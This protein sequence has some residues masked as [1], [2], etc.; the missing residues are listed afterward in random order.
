M[1]KLLLALL[2]SAVL[3][4]CATQAQQKYKQ[5]EMQIGSAFRSMNGCYQHVME[6]PTVHRLSE[7]LSFDVNDPRTVEKLALKRF[8]TEQEAKDIIDFSV[9]RKPCNK[10]A[11]EKFSEIHPEYVASLAKMFSEADA[12]LAKAIN[13]ELTIG[14]VNQRGDDRYN[15]WQAEFSQIGQRIESQLDQAHQYELTQRQIATQSLRTWAYQQQLL[16]NQQQL[17]NAT[18]RPITTNCQ[19]IGNILH[20]TQF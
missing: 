9:L 15:R 12:D 18:K 1:K 19:Y 5:L 7:I 10:L 6:T 20:C 4:G 14:D 2:V 17:I 3:A 8:V 13:K 16:N 11:I